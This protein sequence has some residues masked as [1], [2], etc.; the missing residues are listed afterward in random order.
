MQVSFSS[1]SSVS[2]H[3]GSVV[4][5]NDTTDTKVALTTDPTTSSSSS[6]STP[7]KRRNKH[8]FSQ[9]DTPLLP[10]LL[11]FRES[12]LLATGALQRQQPKSSRKAERIS[13]SKSTATTTKTPRSKSKSKSK[14][15]STSVAPSTCIP[16]ISVEDDDHD[17]HDDDDDDVNGVSQPTSDIAE[18]E[19]VDDALDANTSTIESCAGESLMSIESSSSQPSSSTAPW[20]YSASRTPS[21]VMVLQPPEMYHVESTATPMLLSNDIL[22]SSPAPCNTAVHLDPWTIH[23]VRSADRMALPRMLDPMIDEWENHDDFDYA[24][25][26]GEA[27]TTTT[28]STSTSTTTTMTTACDDPKT[29]R[30]KNERE[31]E[32]M[33]LVLASLVQV[34][35]ED[36]E[37]CMS[38]SSASE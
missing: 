9:S 12:K 20:P 38:T 26:T 16:V 11:A 30:E 28:T 34:W 33:F 1:S 21:S 7:T 31:V 35:E 27:T 25:E 36:L 17:D 37:A 22:P 4:S 18:C 32:I 23:P 3:C 24:T 8:G 14:S 2:I 19:N 6:S 5:R 10:G 13:R 29:A 15:K